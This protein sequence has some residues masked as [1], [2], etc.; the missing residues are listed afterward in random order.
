MIKV[1]NF[2]WIALLGISW[3]AEIKEVVFIP[4]KSFGGIP[5]RGDPA[6]F[7]IALGE[8][9]GE[10]KMG[11]EGVGYFY[12]SKL[13]LI[14]RKHRLFEIHSWETNPNIDFWHHVSGDKNRGNRRLVFKN[15]SPWGLTRKQMEGKKEFSLI[16]ADQFV[17]TRKTENAT[18]TLFYSPF[19]NPGNPTLED[20]NAWELYR[21]QHIRINL[22]I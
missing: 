5:L 4:G 9:E 10:I 16:D 14:F 8:P 13:L 19:Y 12:G 3:G 22:E 18:I 2:A 15:W 1:W 20:L 21:V 6:Q 7:A 11:P 17:E